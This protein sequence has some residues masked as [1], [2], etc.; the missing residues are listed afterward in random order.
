MIVVANLASILFGALSETVL[1]RFLATL[2]AYLGTSCPAHSVLYSAAIAVF[3]RLLYLA[4]HV[5]ARVTADLV[6]E[7]GQSAV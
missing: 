4:T 5:G 7:G 3:P 1:P 6:W 2:L